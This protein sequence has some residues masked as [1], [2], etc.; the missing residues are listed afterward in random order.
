MFIFRIQ[1][2]K[3]K[4]RFGIVWLRVGIILGDR[5][6]ERSKTKPCIPSVIIHIGRFTH[7]NVAFIW[8]FTSLFYIFVF[9]SFHWFT[10]IFKMFDNKAFVIGLSYEVSIILL[11]IIAKFLCYFKC[12][13]LFNKSIEIWIKINN[14][15]NKC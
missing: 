10:R 2:E 11:W 9:F 8:Y 14:R 6:L 13:V 5:S 4:Y 7:R 15:V 1:I 3:R 12:I